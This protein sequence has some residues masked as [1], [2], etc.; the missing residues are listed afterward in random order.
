MIGNWF[1]RVKLAIAFNI[2]HLDLWLYWINPISDEFRSKV[3]CHNDIAQLECNPYSRI[4]VYSASFGR[5]EYES[6]QCP[7]P[8]GVHEESKPQINSLFP[9]KSF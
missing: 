9:V 6:I 3:A 5:T 1:A 4:A 8:Q 2:D 7:Q